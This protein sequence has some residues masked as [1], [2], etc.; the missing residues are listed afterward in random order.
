MK[1]D[2]EK[3]MSRANPGDLDYTDEFTETLLEEISEIPFDRG[4][5]PDDFD[6]KLND[7]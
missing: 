1:T 4:D 5:Y 7:L 2:F 3:K 6:S